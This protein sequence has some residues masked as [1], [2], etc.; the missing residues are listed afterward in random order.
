MFDKRRAAC[1]L[2]PRTTRNPE[3]A[4]EDEADYDVDYNLCSS[5]VSGNAYNKENE[6]TIFL[7]QNECRFSF[8]WREGR[9]LGAGDTRPTVFMVQIESLVGD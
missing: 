2:P 9:A 1:L 7:K 3:Q 6:A 4:A 5:I 8:F